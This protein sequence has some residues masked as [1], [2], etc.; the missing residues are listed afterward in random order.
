[1]KIILRT[2]LFILIVFALPAAMHAQNKK[3]YNLSFDSIPFSQLVQTLELQTEYHFYYSSH[4]LDTS[5]ITINAQEKTL[6]EILDQIFLNTGYHYSIDPR[7]NIFISKTNTILTNLPPGFVTKTMT[8]ADSL[9]LANIQDERK[10]K[11]KI[12]A[13]V[14]NKLF[15][16]GIKTNEIG[17]GNATVAGYI[18]DTKTGE[19][20][21]SAALLVDQSTTGTITDQFGYYSL[22]LP[23]GRH[24]LKISS[25][26]MRATIRQVMLYSDGK[27]NI[28]MD[29][30]IPS[31][32][33]VVVVADKVSNVKGVQMGMEKITIKTIKQLP[34]A[35]G[36][37]DILRA[38]LTLPG[39]TSVG[40]ATTGFNVR[41]GST[42]QNLVLF[43]DANIY[44][45]SHLFGFF[46]AFNP[47]VVQDIELYKSSIP[48]KYGGRLSSVLDVTSRA[49]NKKKISGVGGISPLTSKLTVEGP[50]IK[51]KTTFILGGRTTYSDWIL[52]QLKNEGYKNSRA[53]FYD[54]DLSINHEINAKNNLYFSGYLSNDR[55]RFNK[56]TVYRYQNQ[57][58]NLKWKHIFNNKLNGILLVGYDFY[59]YNVQSTSN[60]VN[61]YKLAFDIGQANFRA[62]FKYT[63]NPK[64]TIG[65]GVTSVL[66]KLH[67]GS[68]TPI[69]DK[70]LVVPDVV[71]PEQGLES[72]LYVGDKYDINPDLSIDAG[73]RYS[74]FNY[75]GAKKV[76]T[77]APGLPKDEL[78]IVDSA[79]YSA[80]KFIK[81][82]QSPEYRVAIRYSLSEKSSIKI[83]YNTL[84]QY[85]H[86]LSNTTAISPTDVWKLS[87]PNIRPQE[88]EQLSLG[89]YR[90]FK[91]NAIETSVEVYY[92]KLKNYMDY[93]SGAQLI[94]NHHI[95]TDVVNTRGKAYG[96]EVMIKKRSGKLNGWLSYTYS[97]TMLQLDDPVAGQT[98]NDGKYYPANF[99]KPN[100]VNLI[101]NYRFSHRFS[102]S[103]DATYSTGRPITLPVAIYYLL[104]SQRVY[105][106]NRN[107]YRIPD[108]FRMDFSMNI[109]GNHKVKQI[110]HN[111]WSLGVYNLT[112]RKNAYSVYFTE[113]AGTIKGY[114]LSIF[115]SAIP[116]ITYNFRF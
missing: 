115:G 61:A 74:M 5:R 38:I 112:G 70:S 47:D 39:V 97:R 92:K 13:S 2:I 73:V 75:M 43:N 102:I 32:K 62:D 91:S 103:F 110:T 36:E 100:I 45:P 113:E 55:F 109:E 22:T 77:Y 11:Q 14:E 58:I 67:P 90:N 56:D 80:G 37:A 15:D 28:E 98:I 30:F 57:N 76:Y 44:N 79:S 20:L 51:D 34:V 82:Y 81:T 86:L 84:R 88:G 27:L 65:F 111:S 7:N 94:L 71:E 83:A 68:F 107:E 25:V 63:P 48:A 49:G 33:A 105:Y 26:G 72:A 16:I 4:E 54:V 93:K 3:L 101:S 31:L 9:K 59:K 50:L 108:Y 69:G 40:E 99:D 10:G 87:D 12:V 96:V 24:V 18:R 106:S 8:Q 35:F 52:K 19:P 89:L 53:S 116:F 64:H 17:T 95:E 21:A 42:D 23:K 46:S 104:G 1:M 29:D 60:P 85:I 6:N 66:Y 41:G 114:K 78:N